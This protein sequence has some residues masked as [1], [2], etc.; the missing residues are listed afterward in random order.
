VGSFGNYVGATMGTS[1]NENG[2]SGA[3]YDNS[4]VT[5]SY[6][7]KRQALLA[8]DGKSFVHVDDFNAQ[9]TDGVYPKLRTT[10]L[11]DVPGLLSDDSTNQAVLKQLSGPKKL[12]WESKSFNQLKAENDA[13]NPTAL[14]NQ[15]TA[16]TQ[17]GTELKSASETFRDKVRGAITGHWSGESAAAAEAATHHVTE[18]SIYDF[19]PASDALKQRLALLS[20]AFAAIKSN[21]PPGNDLIDKGNFNAQQLDA[22]IDEFNSK[23]HI[24]GSGHLRNN[25][26]G[27]VTAADALRELEQIRN[28]IRDYQKAVQLFRDT[29]NPTVEAA[30]DNF[31][32]LPSPPNMTFGPQGPGPNPTGTGPY[33][34]T[35]GGP[36]GGGGGGP[37]ISPTDFGK[38][39]AIPDLGKDL[40]KDPG[41]DL[42]TGDTK[43]IDPSQ[44]D[45]P[46]TSTTSDPTQTAAQALD[47]AL[48][49]ASQALQSGLGAAT[50]AAQQAAQGAMGATKPALPE[51]ALGLGP[52]PE[53]PKGVGGA[54]KGGA[55]A[56][57]GGAG[58]H[59]PA[60][61]L[62]SQ[63]TSA[64]A[65]AKAAMPA[66]ASS[67]MSGMGSPGMGG[68]G[69][70]G[71]GGKGASDGKEHK[72]NKALRTRKNGADIIG[73]NDAVVPV[74]GGEEA[75]TADGD[76]PAPPSRRIP[77]RG[78]T[79]RPDSGMQ[80]GPRRSQS[81]HGSAGSD[82]LVEH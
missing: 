82:Q 44:T 11:D 10:K 1:K 59:Q 64:V 77:Q 21:F 56:A 29:Y 28:S 47:P 15:A 76:Q 57:G 25:S 41:K 4:F 27:Y 49:A 70:P 37:A 81:Q 51:G 48:N 30:T 67:A 36:Q 66:A 52:K 16:W 62:S 8:P 69:A 18:T 20:G 78:D 23:Y 71:A 53:D 24:D 55:A 54:G 79:W 35:D 33:N 2:E 80:N 7:P 74:L 17:H 61:R 50:Q 34:N 14:D 63:P 26:D 19:T 72:G 32:Q 13:L 46:D 45:L 12:N 40:G 68:G 58:A 75:P 31:P 3:V 60:A 5:N 39:K 6:Y 9:P 22:K 73:D 65:G 42:G 43:P 38:N